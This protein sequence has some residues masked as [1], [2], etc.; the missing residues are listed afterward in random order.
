MCVA[1]LTTVML[2]CCMPMCM[3][4]LRGTVDWTCGYFNI[5]YE[6]YD[7]TS[8]RKYKLTEE[9]V[10]ESQECVPAVVYCV[11]DYDTADDCATIKAELTM[12]PGIEDYAIKGF[13][14]AS[15]YF[16]RQ[17]SR[18]LPDSLELI[19]VRDGIP[20]AVNIFKR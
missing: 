1:A 6:R 14:G 9:L 2:L 17:V 13:E 16:H 15:P 3:E 5:G 4:F 20:V 8:R 10:Y 18:P 7:S 19:I 12:T 11:A